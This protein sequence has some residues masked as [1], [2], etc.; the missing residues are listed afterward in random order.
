MEA[1][2]EALRFGF[3]QLVLPEIVSFTVPENR[4]LR[5]IMERLGMTRDAHDDF[6]HP[7]LPDA[8]RLKPHVLYRMSAAR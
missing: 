6:L 1:A 4:R 3:E 8:H 2:R 5:A 7:S